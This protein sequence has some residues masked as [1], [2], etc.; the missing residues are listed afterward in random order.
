MTMRI[1]Q[2]NIRPLTDAEIEVVSGG[3]TN[4]ETP[5]GKAFIAGFLAGG[6][7][8]GDPGTPWPPAGRGECN[9]NHNGVKY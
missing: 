6:G 9:T 2:T 8:M 3:V 1:E 5:L 4:A 7:T